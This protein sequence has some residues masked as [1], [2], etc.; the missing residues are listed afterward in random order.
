VV[1]RVLLLEAAIA[2]G[3]VCACERAVTVMVPA[4]QSTVPDAAEP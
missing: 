2:P 4:L 3:A 1:E